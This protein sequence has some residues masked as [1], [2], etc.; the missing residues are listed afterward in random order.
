MKLT[1]NGEAHLIDGAR[2]VSELLVVLNVDVANLVVELNEEL[3]PPEKYAATILCEGDR[4]ELVRFV[5]G[6]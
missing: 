5:G 4:I 2:K 6:G 1:I 3:V